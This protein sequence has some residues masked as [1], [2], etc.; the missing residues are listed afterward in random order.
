MAHHHNQDK[1]STLYVGNLDERVTDAIVWELMLQA[2]PVVNVHLPKDRVTQNHQGYGFVEFGREEDADYAAKVMNG[3]KL[4]SKQ[5]RVNKASADK[6]GGNNP[7]ASHLDSNASGAINSIGAELFIGN[8]D[9]DVDERVIFDTFK[10]FGS[11]LAVPK[12]ARDDTGKSKG[13]AFISY[14]DFDHSDEA[15]NAMDG[16]Y[17]MNRQITVDYAYK[18]DGK[19][20]RHGDDAE[21]ALAE[22]AKKNGVTPTIPVM[23]AWLTMSSN[24]I[25]AGPAAMVNPGMQMQQ[26][27]MNGHPPQSPA[28]M[29]PVPGIPA[30]GYPPQQYGRPAVPSPVYPPGYAPPGYGQQ[31]PTTPYAQPPGIPWQPQQA[32]APQTNLPAPPPGSNLPP[33]PPAS[34]VPYSGP[35]QRSQR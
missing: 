27:M 30:M 32:M 11:M 23:P 33:R 1:E 28:P 25:P 18:K 5:I 19:G 4:Y 21:R 6:R 35:I 13:Y 17:L 10:Q 31:A 2:G 15:K 16:Q 29:L 7:A 24:N 22:Q 9:P 34:Q 12:V 3:T 14:A 26:P 8:L 20:E